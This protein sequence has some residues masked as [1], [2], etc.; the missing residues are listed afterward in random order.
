MRSHADDTRLRALLVAAD[1]AALTEAYDRHA[2]SA[3]ALAARITGDPCC[4]EDAVQE[5]FVELWRH[6][7]RFDPAAG[8]LRTWLCML[9]RRRAI[10][11]LRRQSVQRTH[12]TRLAGQ[13]PTEPT[14]E[15]D[16]LGAAQA[17]AVRE[18]VRELPQLYRDAIALAY[19]Y[20]LSYRQVAI[21][22][23]VPEGTAKSR[24]RAGLRL[25]ADRMEAAGYSLS[26]Q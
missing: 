21:E 11:L 9:A 24:L 26:G 23:G 25:L 12:L 7:E 3:Y 16:V 10:D 2:P 13:A 15:D 22:L 19:Y 8:S 6:P 20:G 1:E 5:A 14:V 4:A 17:K 18:C